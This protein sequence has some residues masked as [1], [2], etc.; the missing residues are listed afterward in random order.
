[1]KDYVVVLPKVCKYYFRHILIVGNK[2]NYRYLK[3]FE[4]NDLLLRTGTHAVA[5]TTELP[6]TQYSKLPKINSSSLQLI[7]ETSLHSI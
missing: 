3:R 5:R 6:Y 7:A 1:M 2:V 4:Y